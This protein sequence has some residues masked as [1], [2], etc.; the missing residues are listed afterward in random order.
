[1]QRLGQR[2]NETP[3]SATVHLADV[4]ADMRRE[5][6]D[7][8][9]FSAGRAAEASPDYVNR[10]A[11]VA[12]L[13]GDTHQTMAQGKPEY[14]DKVARKLARE[15][16]I[17]VDPDKHVMA[18]LGC[19]NGLTLALLAATNPGDE[20]IV[21]NP[22]FVSYQATVGVCGG[23]TVPVPLRPEN[24]FRWTRADLEVAI[25]ERTRCILFCSPQNPTGTVHTVK[26]LDLICEVALKH[27]LLVIV[28]EIYERVTWGGRRH[29]CL[30]TRP[31][32]QNRTVGLMGFTKTLSMGG[33][34]VGFAYGPEE[35]I[36]AMVT[37]Q[38]HLMTS[39]GSF[40]QT[41]AAAALAEDYRP[42]VTE[43]WQDWEKRCAFVADEIN[44]IPKLSCRAPEGGFYAWINIHETRESSASLSERLL[45]EK[46]MALV[47]GAAFGACG[48]G[49]VRMT[50]VKSWEDLR[51]GIARLREWL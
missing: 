43:M 33:W 35:I 10:V 13:S 30:A 21:E 50:S 34:R 5:G 11:A 39:A 46:Q 23:K 28:D 45:R 8:L 1:M 18:T 41:G 38:Q 6:M 36:A 51:A 4:A 42:E 14:R 49:Y 32:M 7:V 17:S 9:D 19:K 2:V 12:L 3:L 16:D 44:R 26:D 24:G 48:E 22:C 37:F 40:T 47:P 31:G 27:D 29:I 20:V 25:T 15:N